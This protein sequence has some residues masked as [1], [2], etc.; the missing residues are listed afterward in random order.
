MEADTG[1][2]VLPGAYEH[3]RISGQLEAGQIREA[4]GRGE[5]NAEEQPVPLVAVANGQSWGGGRCALAYGPQR[6]LG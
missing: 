5:P 6:E 4:A 3:D 2:G 1:G